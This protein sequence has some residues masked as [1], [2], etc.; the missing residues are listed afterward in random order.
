MR[1]LIAARPFM[2]DPPKNTVAT[3]PPSGRVRLGITAHLVMPFILVTILAA[4]ANFIAERGAAIITSRVAETAAGPDTSDATPIARPGIEAAQPSAAAKTISPERLLAAV[5]GFEQAVRARA[6]SNIAANT[7]RYRSSAKALEDA[8]TA[9][10]TAVQAATGTSPPALEADIQRKLRAGEE[11]IALYDARRNAF[12]TMSGRVEAMS[13]RVKSS[14]DGAWKILGRV[15][16]RQSLLQL[17]GLLDDIRQRGAVLSDS[18][19]YDD[20]ALRDLRASETAFAELLEANTRAFARTDGGQWLQHM[21]DDFA[22]MQA[23]QNALLKLDTERRSKALAFNAL[24]AAIVDRVPGERIAPASEPTSIAATPSP[25]IPGMLTQNGDTGESRDDQS[26]T[27]PIASS[28]GL[29]RPLVAGISI[30][31]LVL[32]IL[33]SAYTVRSILLP[34]SR[35]IRSAHDI[36]QGKLTADIARGGI[37]ELDALADA[38]N[39]MAKQVGAAKAQ[40]RLHQ[41]QLEAKVA[42]RTYQLQQL[43]EHDPLTRLPNRRYLSVLM[44]SALMKAEQNDRRVGVFFVDVDNFKNINDTMGHA[45]GDEV[46]AAIA[47]LLSSTA[48]TFGFAARLGGD[49]FTVIYQS[50]VQTG[51]ID[52]AG[53]RLINAFSAPL[54]VN[55]RE[56]HISVSIGISVFPDHAADPDGLLRAADAALFRA[57]ALGRNQVSLFTAGLLEQAAVRFSTEQGLRR[58][59]DHQEFELWFQPEFCLATMQTRV[60]EALIRWRLPD[61]RLAAPGEFL[62]VAEESGLISEISEWVFRSAIKTAAEWHHGAWPEVRM[63]INVSPRQLLEP[64]FVERLQTLLLEFKVPPNCIEIE[65]TENVLQTGPAT[66]E[67]L[68]ELRALDIAIALDDFGTG[69]SS[70]LSIEQLPLTRIKLDRSLIDS[71]DRNARSAAI[72]RATIGLCHGLGLEVTAEGVERPEQFDVL[73]GYRGVYLQGYL[74]SRPVSREHLLATLPAV[75]QRV[76]ELIVTSKLPAPQS[77]V[78]EMASVSRRKTAEA[79]PQD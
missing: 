21:R 6:A 48:R 70:L 37:K 62:A 53:H 69:Y 42:E 14:V 16:A 61:G 32:L 15:I 57:K 11:L 19:S 27:T 36:A 74:L 20:A 64:Q 75:A 78:V 67:I 30:A 35:L 25:T 17:S 79:T 10:S 28:G 22:K 9:Y 34:V 4:A 73:R 51:D 24:Q 8:S 47:Q 13:T 23:A 45:F 55:G 43:S 3:G 65:L 1:L 71:N 49:E 31:V 33:I 12:A 26:P 52:E 40:T 5:N 50:A 54:L 41:Q 7:A 59:I 63:A 46:L 18:E 60:A 68:Q 58:A 44:E 56:L 76:E 77:N 29:R 38:F 2:Q 39:Q 72:V 66:L